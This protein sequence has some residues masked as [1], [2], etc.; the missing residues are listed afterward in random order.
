MTVSSAE[1]GPVAVG[2]NVTAIVHLPPAGSELRQSW[3]S[4]TLLASQMAAHNHL[5]ACFR[6]AGASG[7]PAGAVWAEAKQ[8]GTLVYASP[9]GSSPVMNPAALKI[10]GGNQPHNNLPP[11]LAVYF[12][13]ALHGI[14][15][16]RG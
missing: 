15:P 14:F 8:R 12:I 5:V 4:V 1:R 13:I 3:L 16:P 10:A 9:A 2:A 11:F 6:A 7:S